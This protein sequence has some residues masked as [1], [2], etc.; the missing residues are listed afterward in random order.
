MVQVAAADL[1]ELAASLERTAQHLNR[2][3]AEKGQEVGDR[4]GKTYAKAAAEQIKDKDFEL[5]RA[6]DLVVELR[7]QIAHLERLADRVRDAESR[8]ANVRRLKTWTDDSGREFVLCDDL[9]RA[10]DP[11]THPAPQPARIPSEQK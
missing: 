5:Q 7:R 10:T 9:R 3:I 2:F 1:A 8:L 11:E 6:G 4:F